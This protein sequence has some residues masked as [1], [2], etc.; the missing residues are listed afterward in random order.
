MLPHIQQVR[1]IVKAII[2]AAVV[3]FSSCVGALMLVGCREQFTPSPNG[4]TS[5]TDDATSSKPQ[6]DG[7]ITSATRSMTSSAD[8]VETLASASSSSMTSEATGATT[9]DPSGSSS[10]ASSASADTET[11]DGWC[12]DLPPG[13]CGDCLALECCAAAADCSGDPPCRCVV[14]CLHMEYSRQ[15]CLGLCGGMAT[16]AAAL[17]CADDHCPEC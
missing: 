16:V 12:G 15:F 13:T 2:F 1:D 17:A 11:G 9:G 7:S 3:L 10:E 5:S 14:E 6:S 8:T 4:S